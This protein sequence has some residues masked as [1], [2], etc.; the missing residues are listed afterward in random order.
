MTLSNVPQQLEVT[1]EEEE[2]FESPMEKLDMITL[3]SKDDQHYI[4]PREVVC[5][6]KFFASM[7]QEENDFEET[8][9]KSINLEYP[10]YLIDLLVDFLFA[11]HQ[12]KLGKDFT[13]PPE[14]L[15]DVYAMSDFLGI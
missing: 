11:K 15:L 9:T 6:C 14:Y 4:I 1:S 13:V 2:K 12:K 8:Q 7:F 10:S 5:Q 3:I